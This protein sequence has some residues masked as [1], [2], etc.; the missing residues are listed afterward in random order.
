MMDSFFTFS[1]YTIPNNTS[2]ACFAAAHQG[3]Y[4][5]LKFPAKQLYQVR[6]INLMNTNTFKPLLNRTG[7]VTGEVTGLFSKV[8]VSLTRKELTATGKALAKKSRNV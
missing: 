3:G 5:F 1:W 8:R 7:E 4:S 2:H 6:S